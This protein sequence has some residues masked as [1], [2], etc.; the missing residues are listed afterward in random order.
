VLARVPDADAAFDALRAER[1]LVRNLHGAH[2]LL[3][4]CL[5]IT[6]GT[7]AENG[8][9]LEVLGRHLAERAR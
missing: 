9:L 8:A 7:S 4:H 3:A 5:R 2:P 6:V 1:I